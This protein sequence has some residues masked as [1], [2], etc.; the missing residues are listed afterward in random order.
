MNKDKEKIKNSNFIDACNNAV[1]GLIYATTTQSNIKKQL[2][3]AVCVLVL[4]LFYKLETTQFLCLTFA[5][6]LV[7][8]AEMVNT[9]IETVV[10]LYTDKY[11]PKAKIAK[12]VAAG[13]VLLMAINSVIVAYFIFL[14]DET[15]GEISKTIF[16]SMVSSPKH[17]VFVSIILTVI[18]ILVFKA[19][20]SKHTSYGNCKNKTGILTK[21]FIPS[22][23]TALA[24][25]IL[26]SIWINTQN[27]LIFTLALML[28]LM[29][30]ENRIESKMHSLAES[31]FGSFMGILIVL[32]VYGLT[33]L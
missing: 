20:A 18:T 31:I 27:I 26:T 15:I 6:F 10:D 1:N 9:A 13:S 12:D 21:K 7:I 17:L 29:V 5:V 32:L 2:V 22:G 24:F 33:L 28:S 19:F 14:K 23:Q 16:Q 30:F 4:S 3:I 25:A 11:H 8:F